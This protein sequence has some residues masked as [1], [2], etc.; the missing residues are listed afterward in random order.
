M[1]PLQVFAG[2]QLLLLS[3]QVFSGP[4]T[5]PSR[6]PPPNSRSRGPH[7][8]CDVCAAADVRRSDQYTGDVTRVRSGWEGKGKGSR[9]RARR[10]WSGFSW[11][12]SLF[13]PA[14]RYIEPQEW[15]G[16]LVVPGTGRNIFR[17]AYTALLTSVLILSSRAR[18]RQKYLPLGTHCSS[19]IRFNIIVSS[20][21]SNRE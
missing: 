14:Y 12:T 8:S 16:P 9:R 18:K 17:W 15:A 4:N 7:H 10:E 11:P 2:V 21:L 19:Y 20:R 6:A 3:V 1:M 13:C 5:C